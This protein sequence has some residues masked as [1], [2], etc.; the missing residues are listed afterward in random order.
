MWVLAALTALAVI[1]FGFPLAASI[2]D[3]RTQQ[4]VLSRDSDLQRFVGLASGYVTTGNPGSLF[5]EMRI[6]NELY[7]DK[8]AVVSTKGMPSHGEGISPDAPAISE[9]VSRA[10]R[11]QAAAD[12]GALTPWG[13]DEVVFA[14]PVGTDGQLDGA[15]L[16]VSSTRAAKADI[17]QQWLY[18]FLGMVAA[19]IAFGVLAVAVSRWVLRP[20][21]LLSHRLRRLTA[22]LPFGSP[23]KEH[24]PAPDT[25][26]VRQGPPEL[27]ALAQSFEQM[28]AGVERSSLSQRRLVA[29]AAHQLRNPLAALQLRLDFLEPHVSPAG[30]TNYERAAAESL[31]F[32]A[33]LDDLLALATAEAPLESTE[34]QKARCVAS[35]VAADRTEFWQG[36]AAGRGAQLTFEGGAA[37]ADSAPD[38]PAIAAAI[39][40]AALRQVLDVLIDNACKYAGAGAHVQVSC[41]SVPAADGTGGSVAISVADNGPG[42]SA[43]QRARLTERFYRGAS[44]ADR[45]GSG[46]PG[47][48]LGLAIADALLASFGGSLEFSA[49]PGGG[50]TAVVRL[51]AAPQRD[52]QHYPAETEPGDGD[53]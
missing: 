1:G 16:I 47:T 7:G 42:V 37:G 3:A 22:S 29:D 46:R 50:L 15:V 23:A 34:K 21:E 4:F 36:A 11:N 43:D 8:L 31:R 39:T 17:G 38:A 6:Y 28:A 18:I 48:G 5:D 45:S 51:P 44:S 2:A 25:E 24:Q 40:E 9:S 41:A 32:T 53:S 13:P 26:L 10:L 20:L 27:R 19:L 33:I 30:H 49:T 14:K 12:L 35:S 52:A